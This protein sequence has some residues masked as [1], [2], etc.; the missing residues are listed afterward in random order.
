MADPPYQYL[1]KANPLYDLA[2]RFFNWYADYAERRYFRSID[3]A[4]VL[5]QRNKAWLEARGVPATINWTGIDFKSFYAPPREVSRE[6]PFT[7][8]AVGA[9]NQYRRFEDAIEAVQILRDAKYDARIVVVCK[10]IWGENEYQEKLERLVAARGLG[11]RV[12]LL[13]GGATEAEL[14]HLY[15]AG[16]VFVLPIHLPPPRNGFGWQMTAFEAMAAG[17]PVLVCRSND[18]TEALMDRETALFVDP[19]RPDQIA[20]SVRSLIDVPRMHR[21][22]A[23]AGQEFVRKNMSWEK[24]ACGILETAKTTRH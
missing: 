3:A 23:A 24:F 9:L 11:E 2:S 13:F 21:K 5:V 10:N 20:E 14:K 15:A 12:R 16:H 18:V 22:I 6:K 19:L 1:P 4:A 17:M 8:V 7:I